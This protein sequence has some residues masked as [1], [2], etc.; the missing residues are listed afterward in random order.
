MDI[1]LPDVP[2]YAAFW[3]FVPHL[4]AT[5]HI[6]IGSAGH[7]L[8]KSCFHPVHIKGLMLY[9]SGQV[10]SQQNSKTLKILNIMKTTKVSMKLN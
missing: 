9:S 7:A 3:F 5:C 4:E 8:L 6:L 1:E 2:L 10:T